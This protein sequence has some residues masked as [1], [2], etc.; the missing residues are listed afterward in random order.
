MTISEAFAAYDVDVL[1]SGG[2]ALKTRKNYK[3]SINL[4]LK[5]RGVDSSVESIT[6]NSIL[7]W[8]AYMV[9]HG[10]TPTY[11]ASNLSRFRNV[12]KYLKRH[13][14]QVL[15]YQEIDRPKLKR[16][17]DP[18]YLE[19]PEIT[20]FLDVIESARDKAI[21]SCLFSSGARISELLSLNIDSIT[22]GQAEIIG[23]GSKPG[24]LLFDSNCLELVKEYLDTR[25]DHLSPLFVSGQ[26][27]RLTVSR[28]E[29]LAHQ[30]ADT[31]R[32]DKNVTPHVFRHSFATDLRMNGMDIYGIAKQLR[33]S[34]ISTSQIYVHMG[35]RK[36]KEEHKIYHSVVP[37]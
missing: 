15:D 33:H 10:L 30:Y 34:N 22:D 9:Q 31:A 27:R 37:L 12:L 5:S 17:K 32:I 35:D 8:K 29:Q 7:T 14:F 4:F 25:S 16:T 18:V 6:Y 24:N 23:K 1:Y 13:G 26:K 2:M 3:C 36:K 28:V 19:L 20:A 11:I 21:F